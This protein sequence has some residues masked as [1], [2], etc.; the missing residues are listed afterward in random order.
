MKRI[1]VYFREDKLAPKGGPAAVCYYYKTEQL[2]RGENYFEFLPP[3]LEEESLRRRVERL[4][5]KILPKKMAKDFHD[6]KE[7]KSLKRLL[8]TEPQVAP[9][10]DFNKYDIIHFHQ[11]KDL[12]LQ[13]NNLKDYKGK[14]ILQS[15]SPLPY[16]QEV[17][18]DMPSKIKKGV[19][20]IENKYE[21]L[22]R[23]SFDRADYLIFPCPEA[24][25]PY[26]NNW[27]YYR[28]IKESHK[29]RFRY[30]LTGIPSCAPKRN[31]EEVLKELNIPND[32]FVISYVGRHNS[33][34][35]YDLLKEIGSQYLSIDINSWVIA[36]GKEEPFKGLNHPRWIEIGWTNDAHSYIA[37]SDVFVLPNRETYFDIVMLEI[38]S[39]G[40]IVLASRTGGNK[41]FEKE[42]LEGVLLYDTIDEAIEKLTYLSKMSKNERIG[43]GF[44]NKEYFNKKLTVNEMYNRY[45]EVLNTII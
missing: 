27:P 28:Q 17:C 44:K 9:P 23:F 18:R 14:V 35:G 30:V 33:V 13:R 34:K 26:I 39:L 7:I 16:G 25:E 11:T 8:E 22:D 45:I 32:S 38:L 4:I 42:G 2:K 3:V 31:R 40:K 36:A 6:W 20:N 21:L 15:H 43:L 41:F 29:D 5:L 37:A 12:Y 10:V 19:G 1:L 24:E